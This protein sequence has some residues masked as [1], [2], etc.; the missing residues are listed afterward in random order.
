MVA[1]GVF[2]A[3]QLI[4]LLSSLA[5][6]LA[7]RRFHESLLKDPARAYAQLGFSPTAVEMVH[8]VIRGQGAALLAISVFLL[9]T[10]PSSRPSYLLI[11]IACTL[12]LLSH[13]G[14]AVH[15]LKSPLVMSV[16]GSISSMY[17]MLVINAVFAAAGF[18]LYFRGLAP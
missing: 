3:F 18:I 7:P 1:T 9:V 12:T 17:P 10:G 5:M 14:T 11:G 2:W 8:N 6:F 15:H 13:L 4:N 16:I